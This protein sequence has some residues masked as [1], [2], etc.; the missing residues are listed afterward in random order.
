MTDALIKLKQALKNKELAAFLM[1]ESGYQ[2]VDPWAETPTD[3]AVIFISGFNQYIA[4]GDGNKQE[5]EVELQNALNTLLNT[6]EG[7][8]WVISILYSYL[9]GYKEN[10]LKFKIEPASLIIPI[11]LSLERFKSDLYGNR[12]WIGWRFENG[13]LQDLQFMVG[14]I[15]VKFK[16]KGIQ[17]IIV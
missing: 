1:G 14:E 15:N 10:S 13:L 8:W 7:T 3:L 17:E 9:I 11:N 2:F 6:A 12:N 4:Q 5:L 16:E